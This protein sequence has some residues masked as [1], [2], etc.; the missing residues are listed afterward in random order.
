MC[1][2]WSSTRDNTLR[3]STF[4]LMSNHRYGL[5]HNIANSNFHL[6]LRILLA[7]D[8]ATNPAPVQSRR[9]DN[10][11]LEVLYLNTRSVKSFVSTDNIPERKVCKITLLQDLV[12][13]G[14]YEVICICE[15]WLSDTIIDS[16]PLPGFR[17]ISET[18]HNIFRQDRIGKIGGGVL[19]S[20]KEGLQVTRRSD[21]ER[22]G[23]ELLVV[24]FNKTNIKPVILYVYYRPPSSSSDG[25]S[26]LNNSLLS[27][28]QSSCIV[29]VGDFNIPS[30]S[31]WDNDS[32]PIS[33]GGCANSEVLC[34]LIGD[35]FCNN[36]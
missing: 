36:S 7:G 3:K 27:N 14:N 19:I 26:L 16:E 33:S 30:I 22:D 24:Q 25:L 10:N 8:I 23:V 20:V 21:L 2:L 15:T 6:L 31:W 12:Y 1:C 9:T 29:L 5:Q 11:C 35:T 4:P 17:N 32:T 34:E 28:P 13:A 18:S